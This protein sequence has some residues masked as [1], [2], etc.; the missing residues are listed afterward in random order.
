[1]SFNIDCRFCDL[2]HE[3]GASWDER[4]QNVKD[5]FARHDPDIMGIEE[6]M[7]PADVEELL[8][9]GYKALYYQNISWL[10]WGAYPDATIFYKPERFTPL[11]FHQFWLGPNPEFPAGFDRLS[12]FRLAVYV[13]FEDKQDGTK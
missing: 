10:P 2:K 5:T 6:P 1:M 7:F 11:D 13:L 8:P 9:A 12:L 4:V 3:N